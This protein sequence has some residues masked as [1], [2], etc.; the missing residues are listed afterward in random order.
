M[1]KFLLDTNICI[2]F[3]KGK[4]NLITKIEDIGEKNC[5]I[6]EITVAELKYGAEKSEKIIE[7]TK[8]VDLFISK[9]TIIPIYTSLNLYAKEK[10]KLSKAG[11]IIDD[12]DLLIASTAIS[13]NLI[14]VTNNVKHFS[15]LKK[16]SINNWTND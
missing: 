2:Y 5:F 14:L 15:R 3:L 12:F 7:N 11:T 4:Y 9:F 10:A 1:T 8:M 13:N 16:L 6:S